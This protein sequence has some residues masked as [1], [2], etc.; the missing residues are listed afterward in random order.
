MA[1]IPP[2]EGNCFPAWGNPLANGQVTSTGWLNWLPPIAR[3]DLLPSLPGKLLFRPEVVLRYE[4][5]PTKDLSD[6]LPQ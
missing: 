3:V 4:G 6:G 2:N 5:A 1:K